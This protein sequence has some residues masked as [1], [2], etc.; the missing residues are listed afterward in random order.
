MSGGCVDIRGLCQSMG[1]EG[2]NWKFTDRKYHIIAQI[3]EKYI[4]GSK[5]TS[6]KKVKQDS[7]ITSMT[8]SMLVCCAV[9]G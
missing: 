9:V 6:I 2:V 7:E 8:G 4:I 5:Q 3:F 1:N